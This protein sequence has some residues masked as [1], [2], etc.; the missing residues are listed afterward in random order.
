MAYRYDP[1][2]DFLGELSS[3]ELNE[4]VYILTHD[5]DGEKR[6]TE[7]LTVSDAYKHYYPD[8]H[9]YW[10]DI[11]AELQLFGGNTF[12]NILRGGRGLEYKEIL[13]DV[14]DKMKVNYNKDSSVEK[15]EENLLLKILRDA[16]ED[17]SPM[18]ITKLGQELG[19]DNTSNLNAQTMTSIFQIIFKL[20]G[21]KSYQLTTI[22]V[23]AVLKALIGRGLSVASNATLMRVMSILTGPIGWAITAIW[24]AV[25]IAGAAY[26]VTIPAVIQVAYLRKLS[27]NR[28]AIEL[29]ND[30]KF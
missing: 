15:I 26:R 27:E 10:K 4:L 29:A 1:A 25:D 19:L 6:Y 7:M 8:H 28:K 24:T 17:M 18:E 22:I 20:G 2:L 16:L 9:M 14:C 30:I 5:K 23:N 13:C 12:I 11:A 3:E 21:F